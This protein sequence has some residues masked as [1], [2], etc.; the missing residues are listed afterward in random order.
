MLF[1]LRDLEGESC[2]LVRVIHVDPNNDPTEEIEESWQEYHV[3]QEHEL[4]YY[5][6][7]EFV[8]WHNVGRVTQIER[9]FL[10]VVQPE[11]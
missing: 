6:V 10:H 1:E 5:D 4:D 8:E 9:E 2:G 7:D 11:S 3:L